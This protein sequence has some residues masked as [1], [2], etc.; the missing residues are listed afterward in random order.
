LRPNAIDPASFT[1][2][3]ILS[4]ALVLLL[5]SR[6]RSREQQRSRS[7]RDV[8]SPTSLFVYAIAFSF[9]YVRLTAGTGALVL[10]GAVQ[11]TMLAAAIRAG[12]R[13]RPIAWVGILLAVGGLVGLTF[14]GLDAPDPLGATLMAVA[15]VS[16]GVYTLRGRG[17]TDPIGK[18]ASNFGWSVPLAVVVWVVGT[19]IV[20]GA[21]ADPRGLTLAAA[22]GGVASGIGYAVW[23]TALPSLSATR[24]AILQL[25]VP[26][27]TAALA[28]V[29]LGETVSARLVLSSVAVLGGIAVVL[30]WR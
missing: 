24:A 28:V 21:H 5:L 15:G 27:I 12:E 20:G 25:S 18:T 10:F 16:W 29:V 14:P 1:L 6:V 19:R 13:P 7:G 23:Y 17:A 11:V 22:S 2:I 9:A 30:R 3:R 26:A 4:G 8:V